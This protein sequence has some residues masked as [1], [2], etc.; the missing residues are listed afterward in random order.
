MCH[1]Q[2]FEKDNLPPIPS[3]LFSSVAGGNGVGTEELSRVKP[4]YQ[5]LILNILHTVETTD[6]PYAKVME[7]CVVC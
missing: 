1:L 5:Q 4:F 2:T 3:N 6:L 7:I